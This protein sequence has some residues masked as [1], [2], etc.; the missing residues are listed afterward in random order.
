MG[1]SCFRRS[2]T[3]L[4]LH[5][6]VARFVSDSRISC[7]LIPTPTLE[8]VDIMPI[9]A[10]V[11]RNPVRI[12]NCP[13]ISGV[14]ALLCR[15]G[16]GSPGT[17]TPGHWVTG[18]LGHKRDK[19]PGSMSVLYYRGFLRMSGHTVVTLAGFGLT[20]RFS[21]SAQLTTG[22]C[23]LVFTLRNGFS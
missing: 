1:G 21:C 14:R 5:K 3:P 13:G 17:V 15:H 22:G 19:W 23:R 11:E 10:Y 16:T 9:V 6:C 4:H 20:T 2:A 7:F 18:S 12:P 8:C